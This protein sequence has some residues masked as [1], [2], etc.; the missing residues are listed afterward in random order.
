MIFFLNV[1]AEFVFF[2]PNIFEFRPPPGHTCTLTMNPS[3]VWLISVAQ[4]ADEWAGQTL[5]FIRSILS[6][7]SPS[8]SGASN[9]V[10]FSSPSDSAEDTLCPCFTPPSCRIL[11]F[12]SH[13]YSCTLRLFLPRRS[14]CWLLFKGLF[15]SFVRSLSLSP[16]NM[17]HHTR[18]PSASPSFSFIPFLLSYFAFFH[19]E[20][21]PFFSHMFS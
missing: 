6:S 19:L 20:N 9:L 4:L 3:L 14:V 8:W 12:S 15:N 13:L 21:S 10:L 7:L 16:L 11:P 5:S 1:C 18:L 2:L 17:I